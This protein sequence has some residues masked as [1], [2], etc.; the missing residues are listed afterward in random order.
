MLQALIRNGHVNTEEVPTPVVRKGRVLIRVVYSCISAGTE[1]A[2]VSSTGK[3]PLRTILEQPEKIMKILNMLRSEGLSKLVNQ[4]RF[5]KDSGLPTGYSVSGIVIGIGEDVENFKIGDRVAA[6][7]GGFAYHAEFVEVPKNLVTLMPASLDFKEAS[8]VA[9]GAIALHGIRRTELK[10]GEFCVVIGSGILGLIAIQILRKSGIRVVAVDINA[11][12]LDIAS[13]LGAEFIINSTTEDPVNLIETITRGHGADAILFAA[14]TSDNKPLAQAFQMCKRKGKVV[15]MG[16]SGMELSRKDMY[17]REIDFHISTSYGPGRYDINYEENG[18]D[19]PYSYVRWTEGRNF[20]EYLRLL[21]TK[22]VV[23]DKLISEVFP[24]ENSGKAFES[25]KSSD[26]KPLI[27]LLDYGLP[28]DHFAPSIQRKLILSAEKP[29]E[30]NKIKIGIIGVGNFV[31]SVH[32][33]NLNKLNHHYTIHALASQSGVKAKNAGS[34]YN[35]NYVTTDYDEIIKDKDIDLVMICTRHGNHAELTLKALQA[36]KHVFVEKPLATTLDDLEQ[37]ER[38]FQTHT[39]NTPLL[40]VGYNRRFSP[41]IREI[42]KLTDNRIGPMFIHYRMNAGFQPA[43]HW[44]HQN[45]GRIIGEACHIVDLMSALTN[46][47]IMTS[48]AEGIK[49]SHSKFL[50]S[51]N[52][53]ITLKYEDGSVAVIEYIS[54][55]NRDLPKEYMEIHFDEKSII[56]SDYKQTE[57][58]GCKLNTSPSKI[59]KKGHF[60]ELLALHNSLAGNCSD[61]PIKWPQLYETTRVTI[62]LADTYN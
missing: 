44:T 49:S 52:K 23:L 28:A 54:M 3:S 42:R 37:L 9:I 38:F 1:M 29:V 34:F 58:Y 18:S 48:K 24:I 56:L 25:L 62:E 10:L 14:A 17:A 53:V 21:A 31:Q 15:L 35:A 59:S 2:G 7:G 5:I 12:R 43:D 60:E 61:W 11:E 51:D 26:H 16:V 32:L 55:G 13:L 41:Y 22:D 30:H 57:S 8:T 36:G 33:P 4:Y 39:S 19:Y 27:V 40:M 20:E 45:G 47:Q 6:A 46:C 50:T